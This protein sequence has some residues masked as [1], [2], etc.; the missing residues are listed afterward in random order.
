MHPGLGQVLKPNPFRLSLSF[1]PFVC[2]FWRL[3]NWCINT[4]L[5]QVEGSYSIRFY[6]LIVFIERSNHSNVSSSAEG[7]LQGFIMD[8]KITISY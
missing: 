4:P 1:V 7:N 8:V 3:R 6:D 2:Y 5:A